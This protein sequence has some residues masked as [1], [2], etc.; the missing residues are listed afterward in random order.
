MHPTSCDFLFTPQALLEGGC[1]LFRFFVKRSG[2]H[3]E[4]DRSLRRMRPIKP[5]Q[6][7]ALVEGREPAEGAMASE[8]LLS[9]VDLPPT[10]TAAEAQTPTMIRPILNK[11]ASPG[12][13]LFLD[14]DTGAWI[15]VV[16][17]LHLLSI[18]GSGEINMSRLG[19]LISQ[20]ARDYFSVSDSIMFK[21]I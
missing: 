10:R 18:L 1:D 15:D 14:Q 21:T 6:N 8:G 12:S 4:F 9:S 13:I 2:R 19:S 3:Y 5:A 20:K 16:S 17:L 11:T 7:A